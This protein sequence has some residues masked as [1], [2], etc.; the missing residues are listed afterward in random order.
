MEFKKE[1]YILGVASKM[2]V[3]AGPVLVYGIIASILAGLIYFLIML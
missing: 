3:I 1:G 2:F